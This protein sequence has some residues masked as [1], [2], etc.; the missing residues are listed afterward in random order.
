MKTI[1]GCMTF[2][3]VVLFVLPSLAG[4][5]S[6]PAPKATVTSGQDSPSIAEAQAEAYNGPKARI[7]VAR[8]TDKTGKGW[9]TG[10]IGD[11]MADQMVT[12]LVNSNRYIVLERQTLS[13]V[14]QEQDLGASGRI[15]QDT[16]AP[17]GQIEGAE[18]LIVGAVTEFEGNASG[19]GGGI[20]GIGG[21]VFGAIAGGFKKAHMAIDVRI[22]DSR[23]SRILA[24]TTVEGESTD[25]K[26]GGALGGYFGGGALGGAL[27]G[28]KNTPTEKA[29]RICINEAVN[30]IISKTPAKYYHFGAQPAA[31]AAPA[32]VAPAVA[33]GGTVVVTSAKL[34]IRS[35]AGTQFSIVDAVRSGD[36]LTVLESAG[37]WYRVRTPSG[38]EGWAYATYTAPQ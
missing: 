4:C 10:S 13:D 22:I 19:G 1:K 29:L 37:A 3:L 15:R 16:A 31:T 35:G 20:G 6:T 26:L 12:A 24:A 28:W 5:V 27:G 9:W 14:M 18:L 32:P 30:F 25:V 7:A 33:A 23:T 38:A 17:V 11:G 36:V 8:F 34:N 2:I 21:G